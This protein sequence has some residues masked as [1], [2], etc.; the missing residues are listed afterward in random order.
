MDMKKLVTELNGAR[1]TAHC[2]LASRKCKRIGSGPR[3]VLMA[4]QISSNVF[5]KYSVFHKRLQALQDGNP[6]SRDY[7]TSE[8]HHH[9]YK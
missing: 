8:I 4:S 3:T 7:T 6:Q 5:E 9:D 1:E 2:K